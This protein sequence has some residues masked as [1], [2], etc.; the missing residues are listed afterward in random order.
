MPHNI[1]DEHDDEAISISRKAYNNKK[2]DP[3]VAMKVLDMAIKLIALPFR[4]SAAGLKFLANAI[5]GSKKIVDKYN[6]DPGHIKR[7]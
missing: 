2:E 4:G 6:N 3:K 1:I 5:A 7:K